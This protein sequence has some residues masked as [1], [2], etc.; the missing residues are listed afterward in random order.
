MSFPNNIPDNNPTIYIQKMSDNNRGRGPQTSKAFNY[1]DS[2][3][4]LLLKVRFLFAI[5]NFN[6]FLIVK[7]GF[8]N[9][10]HL[11]VLISV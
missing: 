4:H 1:F 9:D 3:M 8:I 11:I 6:L 10:F 5:C 7:F 2:S